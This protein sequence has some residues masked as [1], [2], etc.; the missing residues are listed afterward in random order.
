MAELERQLQER[1][2]SIKL[3]KAEK[4][5]R[6]PLSQPHAQEL[7]NQIAPRQPYARPHSA[8]SARTPKYRIADRG[9]GGVAPHMVHREGEF[10]IPLPVV[11]TAAGVGVDILN[12]EEHTE[13]LLLNLTLGPPVVTDDEASYAGI[14]EGAEKS[15]KPRAV[16]KARGRVHRR[17][18]ST[19]SNI[20][21]SSKSERDAPPTSGHAHPAKPKGGKHPPRRPGSAGSTAAPDVH[22][23][24]G[25][26]SPE[27]IR[28]TAQ[29]VNQYLQRL[30]DQSGSAPEQGREG[31]RGEA[32]KE[33]EEEGVA[34]EGEEK[35]EREGGE[36]GAQ[37]SDHP[38]PQCPHPDAAHSKPAAAA[39][40]VTKP[41]IATGKDTSAHPQPAGLGVPSGHTHQA[42]LGD[43]HP[44]AG[45]AGVDLTRTESMCS[46]CSTLS[47]F[48]PSLLPSRNPS[49]VYDGEESSFS[50][51]STEIGDSLE[52]LQVQGKIGYCP[53]IFPIP[54]PNLVTSS[55]EED[56]REQHFNRR[57]RSGP[58]TTEAGPDPPRHKGGLLLCTH[59]CV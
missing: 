23:L 10:S 29:A 46:S 58:T 25:A 38:P 40:S 50:H 43:A 45:P 18:H 52:N 17:T 42:A 59:V 36:S 20:I 54:P 16:Q 1:A 2:V 21:P 3:L 15:G 57:K 22:L 13:G 39:T 4:E 28:E 26:R 11:S 14:R 53:Y 34:G 35:G 30:I 33:E 5:H 37:A 19:G 7:T 31:G 9:K 49:F 41:T 6:L 47:T 56:L 12:L 8:E 48:G 55:S 32:E 51:D 44:K 27:Q 24:S